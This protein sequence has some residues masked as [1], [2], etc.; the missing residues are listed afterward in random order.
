MVD[1]T[2]APLTEPA[3]S[4]PHD[5]DAAVNEVPK[6]GRL[7]LYS[8]QHLLTFYATVLVLP[9]IIAA[10]IHLSQSDTVVLLGGTILAGGIATIIQSVGIW[11]VGIRKPLVLGGSAVVIGPTIA[12]GNAN[13]GGTVGLLA[14]F[15][16][17]IIAGLVLV[18][19]APLYGWLMRLFP[20]IVV[21]SVIAMVGFSLLP[22]MVGLVGGGD[23]TA[24]SFGDT[25][26]LTIAGATFATIILLY[27][28]GR[29]LLKSMAI[30]LGLIVGLIVGVAFGIVDFAPVAEASWFNLVL[31]FHF[32]VPTFNFSAIVAMTIAILVVGVECTS[33]YFAMGE[34]IGRPP[35]NKEIRNGIF[36]EGIAA[37]LGGIFS[38]VP[39]TTF[40]GNVGLVRASNMKSRWVVATAGVLMI[41]LSCLPKLAAVV[42]VLPSATVGA[43]L[44]TL[45][46][47]IATIGIQTL[48][49]VDLSQDRN[50]I[51]VA[52]SLAA[53]IIPTAHP[54]I[55]QHLPSGLQMVLQS[56]IVVTAVVA[57]LL[58]LAFNGL[59]RKNGD[60]TSSPAIE[61]PEATTAR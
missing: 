60:E 16:A 57:V 21:G 54:Q 9:I 22:I 18:A 48:G 24:K 43:A 12:I 14:V 37:V 25:A 50:L 8:I 23:P 10:G 20:P 61:T 56:G 30:L 7:A 42:S 27:R 28:F 46:G 38:A 32:G 31:P 29:G 40:N 2:T 49:K 39:P 59:T 41:L 55:F 1:R 17:S 26:N 52:L 35:T 58:N 36:A 34:I 3:A 11:K 47:I 53:G 5:P 15:G 6:F 44:L 33:S 51:V 13:G 4:P 45:F 19:A